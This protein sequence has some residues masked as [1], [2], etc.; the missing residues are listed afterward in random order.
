MNMQNFVQNTKPFV[1][2]IGLVSMALALGSLSG[3]KKKKSEAQKPAPAK[4]AKPSPPP[5]NSVKAP[6]PKDAPVAQ[7][8]GTR[9]RE[10]WFNEK[11][12]DCMQEKCGNDN[13]KADLSLICPEKDKECRA[14]VKCMIDAKC[15]N[16]VTG[17]ASCYCGTLEDLLD[18]KNSSSGKDPDGPCKELFEKSFKAK[19]AEEV[20]DRYFKREYA[21]GRANS[22]LICMSQRCEK[23]CIGMPDTM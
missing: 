15:V 18:C 3:C 9:A 12:S 6:A 1:F 4:P 16:G 5:A 14:I 7:K 23:P 20:M 22:A 21:A 17:T 13:P 8:P 10:N 19:K 11:C 2:A